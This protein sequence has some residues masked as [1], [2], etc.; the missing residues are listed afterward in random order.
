MLRTLCNML[1]LLL[2]LSGKAVAADAPVTI[3]NKT[4]Y[5]IQFIYVVYRGDSCPSEDILGDDVL[6]DGASIELQSQMG[7]RPLEE[8]I[9]QDEDG[10]RYTILPSGELDGEIVITLDDMQ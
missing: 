4:G 8:L 3:T 7:S 10:D 5:E 1:A 2:L 6:P 9:A